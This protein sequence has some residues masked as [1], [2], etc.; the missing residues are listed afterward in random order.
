M[1]A[2]SKKNIEA[3]LCASGKHVWVEEQKRCVECK[4]ECTNKWAQEHPEKKLE[5]DR[6]SR[7]KNPEKDRE[8][9]LNWRKANPEKVRAKNRNRLARIKGQLGNLP[10]NYEQI[11][12]NLQGGFCYYCV[13][14]LNGVYALDHMIPIAK[15]G[16]HDFFNVCL[17]CPRCNG[18]KFTKTHIEFLQ[19]IEKEK[20][21]FKKGARLNAR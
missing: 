13:E 11:L 12:W 18:R 2:R 21:N 1:A 10:D 3:G 4:H 8:A 20:N 5:H 16:L 15:G 17:A 7:E 6:K 19:V 14:A 9:N